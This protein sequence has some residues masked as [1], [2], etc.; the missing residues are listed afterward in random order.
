[1][2][3]V[4]ANSFV[5]C[6]CTSQAR[7]NSLPPDQF[8]LTRPAAA[9]ARTHPNPPPLGHR[10]PPTPQRDQWMRRSKSVHPCCPTWP[11]EPALLSLRVPPPYPSLAPPGS[12]QACPWPASLSKAPQ[13]LPP[14]VP[15]P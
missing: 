2:T 3:V 9:A 8:A 13:T 14:C 10:L 7:I 6:G 4:V 5:A 15:P 11:P 1:M 12:A